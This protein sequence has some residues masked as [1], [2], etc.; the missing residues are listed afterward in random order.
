MPPAAG[1]HCLQAPNVPLHAMP[2]S[3]KKT[4]SHHH[5]MSSLTSQLAI[6][7]GL[8]IADHRPTSS[9]QA[10]DSTNSTLLH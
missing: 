8:S 1:H 10:N 2:P 6:N 9:G 3:M 4:D 5:R 7:K